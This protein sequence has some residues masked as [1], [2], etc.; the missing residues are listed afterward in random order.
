M[1]SCE[2][3]VAFTIVINARRMFSE[4]EMQKLT[5][6]AVYYTQS[7]LIPPSNFATKVTT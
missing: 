5:T 6:V 4:S 2:A 3:L 7:L 1:K